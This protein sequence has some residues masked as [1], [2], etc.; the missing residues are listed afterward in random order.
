MVCTV[1]DL[2]SVLQ[3]ESDLRQKAEALQKEKAIMAKLPVAD[4]DIL[5]LNVGGTIF[6]TKRAT[7]IQVALASANKCRSVMLG[8]KCFVVQ[9][10][11]LRRWPAMSAGLSSWT[12]L[13][14]ID[15]KHVQSALGLHFVSFNNAASSRCTVT[16][17]HHADS[18]FLAIRL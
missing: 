3:A 10:I 1:I 11:V 2:A 14:V 9:V 7:L 18:L 6:V 4:N 15:C 5:T 16:L 12:F 13:S 17:L 8:A